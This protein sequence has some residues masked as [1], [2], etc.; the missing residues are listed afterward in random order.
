MTVEFTVT[1]EYSLT[2][3]WE[4]SP[5]YLKV[6]L[7]NFQTVKYKLQRMARYAVWNL[8]SILSA[9]VGRPM[10]EFYLFKLSGTNHPLALCNSYKKKS[11]NEFLGTGPLRL[12]YNYGYR[13]DEWTR[14]LEFKSWTKR[15]AF[16]LV[17]IYWRKVWIYPP[18]PHQARFDMNNFV[19]GLGTPEWRLKCGP[20]EKMLDSIGM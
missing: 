13:Q 20:H 9:C 11:T 14:W 1:V 3:K 4:V 17:L 12:H 8:T 19:M 15:F 18:P 2:P 5:Y 6:L 7:L 16:Y 10:I